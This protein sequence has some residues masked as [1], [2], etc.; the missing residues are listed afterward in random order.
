MTVCIAKSKATLAHYFIRLVDE[1]RARAMPDADLPA[2]VNGLTSAKSHKQLASAAEYA[3]VLLDTE[4]SGAQPPRI[5]TPSQCLEALES[6]FEPVDARKLALEM[7]M[8]S[9]REIRANSGKESPAAALDAYGCGLAD[10]LRGL[11]DG[12]AVLVE[13][14]QDWMCFR[15]MIA[16]GAALLANIENPPEDGRVLEAAGFRQPEENAYGFPAFVAPFKL[17]ASAFL[18]EFGRHPLKSGKLAC[19][20]LDYLYWLYLSSAEEARSGGGARSIG[21]IED[22]FFDTRYGA[23]QNGITTLDVVTLPVADD[24]NLYLCV[25][26]EGSQLDMAKRAVTALWNATQALVDL[27]GSVL[28]MTNDAESLFQPAQGAMTHAFHSLVSKSWNALCYHEG[29]KL[30]A[31]RHCGCGVLASNRGPAKEYCSDSCRIQDKG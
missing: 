29:R 10:Q 31:C 20:D 28:G 24:R 26:R 15:N 3:C 16:I 1:D 19:E 2:L 4:G 27:D 7:F 25:R 18:L 8:A 30:I 14:V 5:M 13:P 9:P 12:I 17:Q 21:G 11:G 23:V 22:V 6:E